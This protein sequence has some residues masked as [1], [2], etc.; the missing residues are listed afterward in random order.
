MPESKKSA[1]K[2]RKSIAAPIAELRTLRRDRKALR[3]R[4]HIAEE[5]VKLFTKK[6]FAATTVDEIVDAAD[7][8]T[9]TF[10][11][12][13]VDKEEVVFYDFSERLDELTTAFA[14]SH[15]GNAWVTIRTAFI[16]FARR[17]DEDGELAWRRARLFHEEPTLKFRYLAK[18]HEWENAIAEIVAAELGDGADVV[19]TSRLIAGAA[20][21]AFRSA[22]QSQ[23]TAKK[24]IPLSA[25]VEQA[26]DQLESIGTFFRVPQGARKTASKSTR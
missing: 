22:W 21:T 6:G 10:F 20:V 13:F 1:A 14:Q 4:R 12:M 2:V 9:S 17:W 16:E 26:F 15:P 18:N 23:L 19:L 5:A 7:Y 24:K 11:R 8:S 25:C 3:T